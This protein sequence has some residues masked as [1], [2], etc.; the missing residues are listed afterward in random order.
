[1][2][3]KNILMISVD[4]LNDFVT[5]KENYEGVV[6]AP[7]INSIM[8]KGTTFVNAFCQTAMC[9]PSRTS[10]LTGKTPDSTGVYSNTVNWYDAVDPTETLPAVL[11]NSD[12]FTLNIGK[13]FHNEGN[14]PQNLQDSLFDIYSTPNIMAADTT[15]N[16]F[17]YELYNGNPENLRDY[18]QATEAVEFLTS[19]KEGVSNPFFLS[20]GVHKP[21][22]DWVVPQ[23]YYDLYTLTGEE[24]KIQVELPTI[25]PDDLSDIPNFMLNRVDATHE[26]V[27]EAGVWTEIMQAYLASISFADAMIGR[28]LEALEESGLAENTTIVLWSDHGRH[29]GDKA[30]WGKFTLWE[31]AS[32]APLTIVDPDVGSPGQTVDQVVELLDIFPTILDLAGVAAVPWAEG[33]SL[34]PLL[35]DP[36]A[37]WENVAITQMYGSYSV[38]TEHFRYIRYEDGSEE[39]YDIVNDPHQWKNLAG[40]ASHAADKTQMVAKLQAYAEDHSVVLDFGQTT[41]VGSDGDDV[42]VQGANTRSL[43]GGRGDDVYILN[44]PNVVIVEME[45]QGVDRVVVGTDFVLPDSVENLWAKGQPR[46]AIVGNELDNE[47]VGGREIHGRR[48]DDRILGGA[49]DILLFGERD[50]DTLDGGSGEDT[51]FGGSGDDVLLGGGHN[52]EL[53]GGAGDDFADG[54]W[55][56]ESIRGGDGHDQL[57]GGSGKDTLRGGLGDDILEGGSGKDI[58]DG[59]KGVDTA[60]YAGSNKAVVV[61]LGDNSASGGHAA[62]D[63]FV[64]IENLEGSSSND[65]LTGDDNTNVLWG[66][67]GNDTLD[68]GGGGDVLLGNGGDDVIDGGDGNDS[69]IGNRGDDTLAGGNGNDTLDGGDGEDVLW[70]N[71]GDD[72]LQGGDGNDL[73]R[74]NWGNDRLEGGWGNDTLLGGE[75]DDPLLRG[76]GGADLIKGGDGNDFLVGN[77]GNDTLKG[78]DGNDQLYG[79]TD[80]DILTGGKGS[81]FFGFRD[82]HGMDIIT[83]FNPA[84]GDKIVLRDY[85]AGIG[86]DDLVVDVVGTDTTIDLPGVVGGTI[87][88]EDFFGLEEGDVVLIP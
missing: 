16:P 83:D 69:L 50:N 47:I 21:H 82:G 79:S 54:G 30:M 75:G 22:A 12:F 73:L 56:D 32:R 46:A 42:L 5:F 6:H 17:K 52:D 33:D 25:D 72:D 3:S 27:L 29:F 70:G 65:E 53:W 28:V 80:D 49:Q 60:S 48:G 38:R 24:G 19:Y 34:V 9:N 81:D 13:T 62:G 88:L 14:L 8:A 85:D 74:G 31:E 71:G 15:S 37:G 10:I 58:L 45:G 7:S 86:F 64:S 23:K 36:N 55:G 39:L 77:T 57:V 66:N 76:R 2:P 68:G 84:A 26:A 63:T 11:K 35:R 44:D 51:I 67:A 18:K 78:G 41:S 43:A 20:L 40:E 61:N 59:G 4:D 1:M 87:V